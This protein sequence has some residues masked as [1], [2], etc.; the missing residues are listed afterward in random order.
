MQKKYQPNGLRSFFAACLFSACLLL[1]ACSPARTGTIPGNE[2]GGKEFVQMMLNFYKSPEKFT[3]IQAMLY[4]VGVA[5]RGEMIQALEGIAST[6]GDN[7]ERAAAYYA[8]SSM[9]MDPGHID[10]FLDAFLHD[11][12]TVST[13]NDSERFLTHELGIRLNRFLFKL[14]EIERHSFKAKIAIVALDYYMG[15]FG[16]YAGEFYKDDP[17]HMAIVNKGEAYHQSL[18]PMDFKNFDDLEMENQLS[19]LAHSA[20]VESRMTYY[21]MQRS[22]V[23]RFHDEPIESICNTMYGTLGNGLS[24]EERSLMR[25]AIASSCDFRSDKFPWYDSLM[26]DYELYLP[27]K[28]E[29]IENLLR[30]EASTYKISGYGYGFF[31]S[32]SLLASIVLKAWR[33]SHRHKPDDNMFYT[34]LVE[35]MKHGREYIDDTDFA[36][37]EEK[38]EKMYE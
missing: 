20:D 31:D 38:I 10:G 14:S 29:D 2:S 26:K 37:F 4:T 13:L 6:T 1:S 7:L 12:K 8:L 21:L 34:K 35:F 9:T 17:Y 23:S 3:R 19:S 36:R 5:P 27:D 24:S 18:G 32:D 22:F 28:K 15:E 25:Y 30:L 16:G 11:A 33:K